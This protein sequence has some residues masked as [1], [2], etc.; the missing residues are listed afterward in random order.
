MRRWDAIRKPDLG[1]KKDGRECPLP[2]P[3]D[4]VVCC[5]RYGES[6]RRSRL[7][8]ENDEIVQNDDFVWVSRWPL[9]TIVWRR[10]NQRMQ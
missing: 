4:C 6:M 1:K 2:L 7:I 5:A 3:D 9:R 10:G 8:I